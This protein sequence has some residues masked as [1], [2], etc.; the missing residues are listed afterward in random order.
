MPQDVIFLRF[1]EVIGC[2]YIRVFI[3]GAIIR[4]FLRS[5][6]RDIDVYEKLINN[7]KIT[8]KLSAEPLAILARVFASRGAINR[9]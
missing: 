2:V 1:S 7:Q 8:I 4:G 3:A 9:A 5:H 6:P